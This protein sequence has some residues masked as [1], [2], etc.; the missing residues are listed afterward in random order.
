MQSRAACRRPIPEMRGWG[1]D[2]DEAEGTRSQHQ[3][4]AVRGP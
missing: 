4:M 3:G 1:I 2:P